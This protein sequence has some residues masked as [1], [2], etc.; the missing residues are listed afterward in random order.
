MDRAEKN[1]Q[2]KI[3]ITVENFSK[4][5][6]TYG[7]GRVE[8]WLHEETMDVG[9]G[10]ISIE[11]IDRIRDFPD[12][13]HVAVSDCTRIRLNILSGPTADSLL[14][15]SFLRIRRYTTGRC[16]V[17]CRILSLFTGFS[18]SGSIGSG[19]CPKTEP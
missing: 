17:H 1:D 6:A 4:C 3:P 11:D 5:I 14:P 13:R 15:S 9:G 12:A 10:V 19:I 2:Y 16:W 7:L 8:P 18:I